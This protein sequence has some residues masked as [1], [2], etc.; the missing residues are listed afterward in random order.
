[1]KIVL[2]IDIG[3]T[4]IKFGLFSLDGEM[5]DKWSAKTNLNDSGAQ[6][7]PS[8]AENIRWHLKEKNFS[9]TELLGIGLGIPGP[10][11]A[12]G[13]VKKC[14]NLFWYDFDPAKEL[15]RYFPN[16]YI[17][18]GNDANV[19]ALGEYYKGAGKK[20][21]S[22]M[23]IT[24][25][26]GVGGGIIIDGNIISGAHGN[27]GEIGHIAIDLEQSERCN[28]GNKGC[29]DQIASATGIVR[30]MKHILAT[31]KKESVLCKVKEDEL[32]AKLICDY[33][34]EGDALA[35]HCLEYCMK[36]LAKGMV[37]FS[38]AFEPEA[39]LIGGG[40]SKAGD[41]LIDAIK[42]EYYSQLFL[43][44]KGADIITAKLGN[45]AGII[46]AGLLARKGIE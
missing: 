35:I 32:T 20:Y 9:E 21:S 30:R 26:T 29:I 17:A 31:S 33:A 23:M 24:L 45:D 22:I 38:H 36:I 46:G 13:Y 18:V 2:G 4:E 39:F 34:R 44:E 7:I 19:A 14:V 15:K 1:M 28:C 11:D 16:C 6:I 5:L 12:D 27:A 37:Y 3:G 40:V 43:I 42:R 8:I 25:G 41:V 10:V